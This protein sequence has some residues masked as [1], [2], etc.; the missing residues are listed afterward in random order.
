MIKKDDFNNLLMKVKNQSLNGFIFS[1]VIDGDINSC[2]VEL[3]NYYTTSDGIKTVIF[4]DFI[5]NK[6][7]PNYTEWWIRGLTNQVLIPLGWCNENDYLT[8]KT[9]RFLYRT[10]DDKSPQYHEYEVNININNYISKDYK[11]IDNYKSSF[12]LKH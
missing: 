6:Y 7:V 5:G 8:K 4:E 9:L 1:A 2:W 3:Y 11:E 12:G 10:Y